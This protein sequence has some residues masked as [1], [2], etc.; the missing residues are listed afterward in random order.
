MK[1]NCTFWCVIKGKCVTSKYKSTQKHLPEKYNVLFDQDI[2]HKPPQKQ[3]YS[4]KKFY[5]EKSD[6]NDTLL[7]EYLARHY[8]GENG[9]EQQQNQEQSLDNNVLHEKSTLTREHDD[10]G[11]IGIPPERDE[12]GNIT[13]RELFD[14][15]AHLPQINWYYHMLS[16][17]VLEQYK[18]KHNFIV[19]TV[20]RASTSRSY[21][22]SR[23]AQEE[24][25][26]KQYKLYTKEC[27]LRSLDTGL[28]LEFVPNYLS[29]EQNEILTRATQKLQ[30]ILEERNE[31]PEKKTCRSDDE[32]A[33]H[34]GL[35]R[36]Y[37]ANIF[38]VKNTNNN[39]QQEWI[40]TLRQSGILQALN[41]YYYES[42][43]YMFQ[44]MARIQVPQHLQRY[45]GV[46]LA[47]ALNFD[48]HCEKH[49]DPGN[50]GFA[51]S[52]IVSFGNYT[53]GG[54]FVAYDYYTKFQTTPG[55]VIGMSDRNCFHG[56]TS[57]TGQRFVM[58]L[59]THQ[60]CFHSPFE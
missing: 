21:D 22:G 52:I 17:K 3:K 6:H 45:F 40:A 15:D 55:S 26:G 4:Q 10:K 42:H 31:L 29:I 57:Y 59:F 27:Q 20:I 34:M 23:K 32:R 37:G 24:Q 47:I 11:N 14:N 18:A 53:S 1:P 7:K 19:Q 44:A 41:Q 60:T 9:N 25:F 33:I 13:F 28:E 46:L 2:I 36:S 58:V 38:V 39:A 16:E 50:P 56:S 5:Y 51:H 8:M 35:W 30:T 12:N 54:E 43:P 49:Q 48:F